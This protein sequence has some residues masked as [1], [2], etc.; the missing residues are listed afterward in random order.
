MLH[1][2]YLR[3]LDR[4]PVLLF[5]EVPREVGRR[6]RPPRFALDLMASAGLQALLH[7]RDDH[8]GGLDCGERVRGGSEGVTGNMLS[9]SVV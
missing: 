3:N 6:A 2:S 1:N 7:A 9:Q 4:Q 8:A 5:L